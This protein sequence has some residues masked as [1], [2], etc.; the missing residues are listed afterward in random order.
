MS[1]SNSTLQPGHKACA[2]SFHSVTLFVITLHLAFAYYK[3][4]FAVCVL[5][6]LRSILAKFGLAP[7]ISPVSVSDKAERDDF[8][9]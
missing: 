8:G 3:T 4:F 2:A 5:H 6:L 9:L 7:V 1:S